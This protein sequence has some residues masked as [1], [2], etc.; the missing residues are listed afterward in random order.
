MLNFMLRF[1]PCSVVH[2]VKMFCQG[3]VY[4]YSTPDRDNCDDCKISQ[5]DKALTKHAVR[6]QP[7]LMGRWTGCFHRSCSTLA[8]AIKILLWHIVGSPI[9]L[10]SQVPVWG[11]PVLSLSR[12][13]Q[14]SLKELYTQWTLKFNS[15]C[16]GTVSQRYLGA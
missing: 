14:R 11:I 15:G 3:Y 8:P 16:L 12:D 4:P 6:E 9:P 13:S 7:S 5:A 1:Q 10:D 2:E